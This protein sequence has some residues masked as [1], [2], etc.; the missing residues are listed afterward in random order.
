MDERGNEEIRRLTAE[1][2]GRIDVVVSEAFADLSRGRV[3]RMLGEGA[4]TIGGETARKS[5]QV[6]PG[7]KIE[8]HVER[9][10]RRAPVS[11]PE[12]DVVY[13]DDSVV[14]IN[15][16][17][18]VV[19]HG[20]PGD[21][22]PTVVAWFVQRYPELAARFDVERPGVVHR[23]DKDTSGIMVLAKTPESQ[24]AVSRAF[25]A[26][27]VVKRY[28]AIVAGV[29]AKP[30]ARID[31]PIGRHGGDR[32]KMAVTRR[33]RESRTDYETI[34]DD[35]ERALLALR[36]HT[37][38]THQIRVHLAAIK[39]PVVNDSTYGTA[40][41]GRQL[42][43][44]W[45]LAFPHPDGGRLTVTAPLPADMAAAVRQM[46]L[47]ELASR[48]EAITPPERTLSDGVEDEGHEE[49]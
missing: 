36:L 29:P 41:D 9:F 37:G 20:G 31:A 27:D 47:E 19:V 26:R 34:G 5:A 33:G 15:K 22:G 46:G 21:T 11:V 3:Q 13:E 2:F 44:A 30:R 49:A 10:E 48:Y 42:L 35:G 32:T 12:L 25:E 18:G 6:S 23:L 8:V 4:I 24:G 45:R 17:A 39:V 16:A 40:G 7:D 43:H 38:R 28:L 1:S 14:V